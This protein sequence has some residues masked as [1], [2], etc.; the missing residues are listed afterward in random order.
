MAMA[1]LA[2]VLQPEGKNLS[3]LE[4]G[5]GGSLFAAMCINEGY[6]VDVIDPDHMVTLANQQ[7]E[8]IGIFQEDYMYK[9]FDIKYDVVVCL[10]VLEHIEDDIDFFRKM[11][12]DANTMIFLTVDFS[13]SG[14]TFSKDHLRTY[15]A[16]AL[17][18]LLAIASEYGFHL[19]NEM[20]ITPAWFD[21]GAH[22]YEYNFASLC[23]VNYEKI[24]YSPVLDI[25][26]QHALFAEVF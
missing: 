19:P 10:S 5:S 9:H 4:I 15:T 20:H 13:T 17:Y 2:T 1:A 6:N 21:R 18:E 8:D 23:L 16:D 24:Q 26:R 3:V 14:R 11:L 22:V 12:D 25:S 7:N